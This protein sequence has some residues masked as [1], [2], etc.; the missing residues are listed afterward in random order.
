MVQLVVCALLGMEST[1][2]RVDGPSSYTD[3]VTGVLR[4]R[5]A[6]GG[7]PDRMSVIPA[8]EGLLQGTQGDRS[9]FYTIFDWLAGS[10]DESLLTR[11][12][13]RDW[14]DKLA[15]WSPGACFPGLQWLQIPEYVRQRSLYRIA[16]RRLLLYNH[17]RIRPRHITSLSEDH[18]NSTRA[19]GMELLLR[20]LLNVSSAV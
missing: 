20:M 15:R 12:R 2:R 10:E 1:F 18:E 5:L 13:R 7:F 17:V 14:F 6:H 4:L 8:V 3:R 19:H 16:R 11:P 9:V